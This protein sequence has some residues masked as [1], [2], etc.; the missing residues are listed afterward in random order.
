MTVEKLL[1]ALAFLVGDKPVKRPEGFVFEFHDEFNA[2]RMTLQHRSN[3]DDRRY[4][5]FLSSEW[6]PAVEEWLAS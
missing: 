3:F 2:N 6:K 4:R 5:V 1:K